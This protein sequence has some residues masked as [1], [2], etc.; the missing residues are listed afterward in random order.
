MSK[1]P[2]IVGEFPAIEAIRPEAGCLDASHG[3]H[4]DHGTIMGLDPLR[5]RLRD[6]RRTFVLLINDH[7][8]QAREY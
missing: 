1:D 2:A 7:R 5:D 6:E 4:L 8:L 3:V